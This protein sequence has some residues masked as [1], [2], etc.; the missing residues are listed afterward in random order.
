[1][2]FSE[3]FAK[4]KNAF[5]NSKS[6]ATDLS[7]PESNIKLPT[8]QE[9][10]NDALVDFYKAEYQTALSNIKHSNALI[11]EADELNYNITMI[12]ELL[13]NTYLTDRDKNLSIYKRKINYLINCAK[14]KLYLNDII[15]Y[16]NEVI[17]RLIALNE[18]K[19]EKFI[20]SRLKKEAINNVLNRLYISL[21]ILITNQISIIN[22]IRSYLNNNLYKDV[23]ILRI[24][25]IDYLTWLQNILPTEERVKLD[26]NS[27]SIYSDLAK[28]T[29]LLEKYVYMHKD[30]ITMETKQA[31]IEAILAIPFDEKHKDEILHKIDEL[32]IKY[33]V[34][35]DYA[36]TNEYKDIPID[37]TDLATLYSLKFNA[38]VCDTILVDT[39]IFKK[40]EDKIELEYYE[41]IVIDI[42]QRIILG[43]NEIFNNQFK[44]NIGYAIN[45]VKE[46]YQ[47]KLTNILY[48][49][50]LLSFLLSFNTEDG[51]KKLFKCKVSCSWAPIDTY[52]HEAHYIQIESII[53]FETACYLDSVADENKLKSEAYNFGKLYLICSENNIKEDD[54]YYLPEGIENLYLHPYEDGF[55][56]KL[57]KKIREDAKNK[58]VYFPSTLK[59]ISLDIF[60]T[61]SVK[62]FVFNEGLQKID[63]AEYLFH[64]KTIT[65]PST[66]QQVIYIAKVNSSI[67]NIIFNMSTNGIPIID[68]EKKDDVNS[69]LNY[70]LSEI[71]NYG[72]KC[73]T[74]EE[75][76]ESN[77]CKSITIHINELDED[78]II[79]SAMLHTMFVQLGY[80]P[81]FILRTFKYS[82]YIYEHCVDYFKSLIYEKLQTYNAFN[83]L[84]PLAKRVTF[85]VYSENDLDCM[86]HSCIEIEENL[87]EYL[88]NNEEKEKQVLE[89]F[90]AMYEQS[91]YVS[92]DDLKAIETKLL[93]FARYGNNKYINNDTLYNF[94]V[95]KFKIL[96]LGGK[97]I[98][99]FISVQSP[100]EEIACYQRFILET[101]QGIDHELFTTYF[102]VSIFGED[103][104]KLREVFID[105]LKNGEEEIDP[106]K[107]LT[108]YY[109][110]N[111]FSAMFEFRGFASIFKK[112]PVNIEN[113]KL[114]KDTKIF[115]FSNEVSLLDIMEIYYYSNLNFTNVK[116]S[117]DHPYSY[118]KFRKSFYDFC[119][120]YLKHI[121][122]P[123][124]NSFVGL[125]RFPACIA[126]INT[127]FY[128]NPETLKGEKIMLDKLRQINKDMKVMF[129]NVQVIEGDEPLFK[130]TPIASIE[131]LGD[132]TITQIKGKVFADQ[133]FEKLSLPSSI[134][135]IDPTAFN[136][137]AITS[138][139]FKDYNPEN[140]NIYNQILTYFF[141]KQEHEGKTIY[142]TNLQEIIFE[143]EGYEHIIDI[144]KDIELLGDYD[145]T[146]EPMK[147]LYKELDLQIKLLEGSNSRRLKKKTR[148]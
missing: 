120:L 70:K 1:M 135:E 65:F 117:H 113:D 28:A 59:N 35:Y 131:F 55:L 64:Y 91:Y 34:F 9:F 53:P 107:I 116:S 58:I 78:V 89:K 32:E 142:A 145:L 90:Q 101:L 36:S 44:N 82:F 134:K 88:Q 61:A 127:S 102:T 126:K 148:N 17:A 108:D 51:L 2:P 114:F 96:T 23:V 47:N 83:D 92:L 66:I 12:I 81:K 49:D 60:E 87:R 104:P 94:Y 79:N 22:S 128:H 26:I 130:D 77:N 62:G 112:L 57:C 13:E 115:K 74:W 140:Y 37:E 41:S 144:Q 122:P 27:K 97:V 98:E 10:Q 19:K 147:A 105:I 100:H 136:F 38:L 119:D 24:R 110:L 25:K 8:R 16:Q 46:I 6:Y 50:V 14:L 146:E 85:S 124:R 15:T 118:F 63:D 52:I 95:L 69:I 54:K 133:S 121:Y 123:F 3:L 30:E 106:Y 42:Y 137:S 73:P 80:Y 5:K 29:I 132:G 109:L 72:E 43:Q 56:L 33:R 45:L 39:V 111:I 71:F 48:D 143:Y 76:L 86:L 68:N 103:T 18:V 31:E 4:L 139:K 129:P 75:Y 84:F 138:L 93:A 125:P 67:E 141:S 40:M 11:L 20:L 7:C 21:N 99:P